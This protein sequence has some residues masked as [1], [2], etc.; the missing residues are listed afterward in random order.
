MNKRENLKRIFGRDIKYTLEIFHYL[1]A[2]K[3]GTKN[4]EIIFE[5]SALLKSK[6]TIRGINKAWN[7]NLK[8]EHLSKTLDFLK[9]YKKNCYFKTILN[10]L[11]VNKND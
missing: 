1:F 8:A 3:K 7:V 5:I 10:N 4:N 9:T 2:Y 6:Q 11:E